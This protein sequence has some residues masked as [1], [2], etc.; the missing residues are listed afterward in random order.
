[1][2]YARRFEDRVAIVTG[3][4]SGI[5][6]ATAIRLGSEGARV[7]VADLNAEKAEGNGKSLAGQPTRITSM[8]EYAELFGH[9]YNHQFEFIG[10]NKKIEE[11]TP[12]LLKSTPGKF[13]FYNCLRLFYQNGGG[14]CYIMSL[15]TYGKGEV[16]FE[17]E[18]PV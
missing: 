13:Y 12:G 18:C 7:N 6:L 5:G 15:G 4:A 16:R 2:I 9:G 3:G 8:A 1:M 11:F 14:N 17:M 10:K